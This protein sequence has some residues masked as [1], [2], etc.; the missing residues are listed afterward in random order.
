MTQLQFNASNLLIFSAG[1]LIFDCDCC[2]GEPSCACDCCWPV[3]TITTDGVHGA[4]GTPCG[5]GGRKTHPD[6]DHIFD[7][8][9]TSCQYELRSGP[10][11][12]G[13]GGNLSI[14]ASAS[15]FNS[16]TSGT[17]TATA[18]WNQSCP[19]GESDSRTDTLG[20]TITAVGSL[21]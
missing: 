3:M 16:H 20:G 4:G 2:G 9:E 6:G 13:A 7:L 17:C 12:G 14:G 10:G 18:T 15:T 21:T 8:N 1:A 11:P 5:P 19:D